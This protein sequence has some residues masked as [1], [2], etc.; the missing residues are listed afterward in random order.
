MQYSSFIIHI[1]K[2]YKSILI[3]IVVY[4]VMVAILVMDLWSV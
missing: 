1:S 3:P 4:L 2:Y